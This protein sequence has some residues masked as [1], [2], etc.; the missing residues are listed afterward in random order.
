VQSP[1]LNAMRDTLETD[2]LAALSDLSDIRLRQGE[3]TALVSGLTG[4]ARPG[5][6]MSG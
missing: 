4:Q 5:L 2:R 6:P 1:W 3:H